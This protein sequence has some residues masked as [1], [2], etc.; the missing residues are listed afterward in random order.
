[1]QKR[2]RKSPM[3]HGNSVCS[4]CGTSETTLW[5]RNEEG[6]TECNSC[7]LYF[8]KRGIKRPMSLQ[9]R[10]IFKR[11]RKS[12]RASIEKEEEV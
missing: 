6:A 12:G 3:I 2:K 1:G 8:K 7:S 4:N 9:N 5:R 11:S 10:E